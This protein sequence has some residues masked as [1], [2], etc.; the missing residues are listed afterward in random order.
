MSE[1]ERAHP[2]K[3]SREQS[4]VAG[5][6]AAE[7]Q[8]PEP[9]EVERFRVLQ[10]RT[11]I[12]PQAPD[13]P[14]FW[15][16]PDSNLGWWILRENDVGVAGLINGRPTIF[17]P[18][19]NDEEKK[20]AAVRCR[21]L[22]TSRL[23]DVFHDDLFNLLKRGLLGGVLVLG[24]LFGLRLPG[25]LKFLDLMLLLGALGYSAYAGLRYGGRALQSL[26]AVNRP[27]S[28]F[29]G[30]PF[31]KSALAERLTHAL[32]FRREMPGEK[33]GTAPDEELLDAN[34]YRA[35]I[36]QGITTQRELAALGA[37]ID[38]RLGS[39]KGEPQSLNAMARAE[40][41]DPESASLY[42]DLAQAARELEFT[43]L[44]FSE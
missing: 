21:E 37:A 42:R 3:P 24:G 29:A 33:R 11:S 39:K 20:S 12:A 44:D 13:S 5:G 16:L 26:E 19:I 18:S 9:S 23:R 27:F 1:Q 22:V 40:G 30:E 17:T 36:R 34:A 41:I 2:P 15:A 7:N 38:A 32:V 10:Q 4:E 6:Q 14:R 31:V 8:K 25:E 35:L 43:P 28:Q